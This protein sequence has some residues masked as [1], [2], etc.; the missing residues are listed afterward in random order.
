MAYR[1]RVAWMLLLSILVTL[2]PYLIYV[3]MV[4]QNQPM[5][6]PGFDQLK[7]YAVASSSFALLVGLGY[8]V[9]RVKYPSEA[10]TPADERD[11]AIERHTYRIGYVILLTGIIYV[12]IFK[13]FVASGWPIVNDAIAIVFIAEVVRDIIIV[14]SYYVQR[15]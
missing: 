13:P 14:R 6:M 8:W 1:E 10:K 5:P 12:G 4:Q 3:Y 9:L 15:S 7:I 2:G 11:N